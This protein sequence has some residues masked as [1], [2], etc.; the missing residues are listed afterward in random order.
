MG[1]NWIQKILQFVGLSLL[2][3]LVFNNFFQGVFYSPQVY[4]LFLILLPIKFPKILLLFIGFATGLLMDFFTFTIGMH[5][6]ACVFLC[7]IRPYVLNLI[8]PGEV[9]DNLSL[10]TISRYGY[11]W[12]LKY[13]LLCTLGYNVILFYLEK[14]SFEGFFNTL[15]S[16]LICTIISVT[17]IFSF[18]LINSRTQKK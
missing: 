17:I 16:A 3:I 8:N 7:F 5:A 12:F 2:Q 18:A 6:A 15:F 9:Y 1:I 4:I 14:F 11:I 13:S 10:P